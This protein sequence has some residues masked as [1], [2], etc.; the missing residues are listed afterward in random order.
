LE[1]FGIFFEIEK[2]IPEAHTLQQGVHDVGPV[3]DGH[4]APKG[5]LQK[6]L[7]EQAMVL[8]VLA[9]GK[10]GKII[11]LYTVGIQNVYGRNF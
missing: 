7:D 9:S 10:E 2:P 3:A 1:K 6:H 8:R 4:S 5:T 11:K